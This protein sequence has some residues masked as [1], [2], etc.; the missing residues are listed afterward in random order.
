MYT[1][2]YTYLAYKAPPLRSGL[3]YWRIS[4]ISKALCTSSTIF[5]RSLALRLSNLRWNFF[6]AELNPV[7][8]PMTPDKISCCA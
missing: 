5:N 7:P 2:T 1:N 3:F 4:I 6:F 8:Y